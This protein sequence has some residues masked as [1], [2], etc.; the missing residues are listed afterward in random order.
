MIGEARPPADATPAVTPILTELRRGGYAVLPGPRQVELTGRSVWLDETWAL[1]VGTVGDDIAVAMLR[2]HLHDELG[3]VLAEPHAAGGAGV[4]PAVKVAVRHGAVRTGTG[5]QRDEQAYRIA[6]TP[7]GVVVQANAR[8]GLFYAVQTLRQLLWS[9]P[10]TAA[11]LAAMPHARLPEGTI[12]DWPDTALRFVHWDTK[13]HQDRMETLKRYLDWMA[14]LKLNAV[15][16]ELEDKFEYPSHPEIGCPG[17]FTAAQL[18]ELTEYALQRHIQLVPN[19]QAPAHMTYVLKHPAFA[20]LKCDGNNYQICM[21]E[22][23]ARRLIF[24]MYDD[25]CRA[26]P[27]VKYFHVSTDEVYYAGICE[28]FR[29]PYNPVNRSLTLVDFIY[30]AHAH[31]AAQGRRIIIWAEFPLLTEHLR[32]LPADIIN[33]ILGPEVREDFARALKQRGLSNLVYSSM[34]GEERLFPD[35]FGYAGPDGAWN[36]GRLADAFEATLHPNPVFPARPMGTFA[37]AWDD[38]GL[39][40]ETFW[41]GWAAMAQG[42]WTAGA[43]SVEQT[44]A[45]F[46]DIYYGRGAAG[47]TQVYRDMQEQARFWEHSWLRTP[48]SVRGMTYGSSYAKRP[49]RLMDMTLPAPPLPAAGDL[50]FEP[51]YT[52]AGGPHA[53]LLAELPARLAQSDRLLASLHAALPRADRN[54]YNLEV[55]LSLATFIRSHLLTLAA[56]GQIERLLAAARQAHEHGDSE[57]AVRALLRADQAAGGAIDAVAAAY[58]ELQRVWELSRHPRNIPVAG[59]EFLHV[60][61]DVK[62]HFADRRSDLTYHTAPF[63]TIALPAWRAALAEAAQAYA[64][65]ASGEAASARG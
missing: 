32:L 8:V 19:V 10:A 65:F 18:Q 22:P 29:Q 52:A 2:R 16:F 34:Q 62:D 46:M 33:G 31:L 5:D 27:G 7:G 37:A 53:R 47:M 59:R 57:E 39:H 56:M 13:H 25:L 11:D 24:D 48:S 54:R 20:H 58:A 38:A 28:K 3:L 4:G 45:D 43:V 49:Y 30:A 6:I 51:V 21:D 50:T 12:T 61:D 35:H 23:E 42:A 64:A 1:D 15:S 14:L 44:A 55:F 60:M 36:R 63:D 9:N 26:T 41:L 40:N 17:A